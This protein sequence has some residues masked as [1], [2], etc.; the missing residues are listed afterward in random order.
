MPAGLSLATWEGGYYSLDEI[1]GSKETVEMV[2]VYDL[3]SETWLRWSP[4]L[5]PKLRT[6]TEL[7]TGV[8][9]WVITSA[10]TWVGMP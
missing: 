6:L 5:D 3:G 7:R 9:Y 8:T 1:F 2:Y 10:E 4:Q